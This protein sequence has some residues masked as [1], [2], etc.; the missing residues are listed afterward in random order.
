MLDNIIYQQCLSLTV[1]NKSTF[2][3]YNIIIEIINAFL[4]DH[5]IDSNTCHEY[6]VHL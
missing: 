4:I 5:L 3:Q 1:A 6:E 2:H